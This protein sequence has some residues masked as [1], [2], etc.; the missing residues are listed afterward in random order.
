MTPAVL[1]KIFDPFFTTKEV[2]KGTGLGL[3]AV[4]GIVKGHG[5]TISVD[6]S[7]GQGTT[8]RIY[9]PATLAPLPS[10]SDKNET[11]QKSAGKGESIL[12]VDDEAG[13]RNILTALLSASG[14]RVITASSGREA[15]RVYREHSDEISVVLTD[16]M[17]AD[18][19]GFTLVEDLRS[20]DAKTPILMMSG[21]AGGGQYDDRAKRLGVPM[22]SKPITRDALIRSVHSA[23]GS[24]A[25]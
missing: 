18:G 16:V 12:L 14:F 4:R 25:A 15:I 11:P 24:R 21:L 7:P 8:F 10:V 3:A 6:S 17:M 2:G 9:L 22:L 5:G 13:V 1:D 20:R 23:L 19:D